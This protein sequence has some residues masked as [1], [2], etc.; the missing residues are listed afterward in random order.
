MTETDLWVASFGI[1]LAAMLAIWGFVWASLAYGFWATVIH[2]YLFLSVF[3]LL[4]YFS[5][6]AIT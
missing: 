2:V 4:V 6:K 5:H 3:F 1:A